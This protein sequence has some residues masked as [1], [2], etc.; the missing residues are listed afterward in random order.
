MNI[1]DHYNHEVITPRVRRQVFIPSNTNTNTFVF[2]TVS[3][4]SVLTLVVFIVRVFNRVMQSN[5]VQAVTTA[6]DP[7]M[8]SGRMVSDTMISGR[9]FDSS[10]SSVESEF[11]Q[12]K[13]SRL[14]SGI[15]YARSNDSINR[16]KVINNSSLPIINSSIIRKDFLSI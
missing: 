10:S 3:F 12:H 9:S 13:L 14:T 2:D 16:K 11:Q 15:H 7:S 4:L 6:A 5:S 8:V 1:S